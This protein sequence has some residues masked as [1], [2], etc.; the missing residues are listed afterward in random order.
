M[1]W[2]MY[3]SRGHRM[4]HGS[5]QGSEACGGDSTALAGQAAQKYGISRVV[6]CKLGDV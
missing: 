6:L 3:G 1:L 4:E 5:M 2:G